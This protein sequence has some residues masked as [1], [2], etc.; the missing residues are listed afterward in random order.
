MRH[1]YYSDHWTL[2]ALG[3][4]MVFGSVRAASGQA[5]KA[6]SHGHTTRMDSDHHF[7]RD[8]ADHNEAM[9]HLAHS[10]MQMKHAHAGGTDAAGATDVVEDARKREIVSLLRSRFKDSRE[11]LPPPALKQQV[12][13]L[14]QLEGEAYEAG[15]KDFLRRHHKS[16]IDMIDQAKLRR[17]DV[18]SLVRKIR[19]QYVKEMA[20]MGSAA[21]H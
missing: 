7:L 2:V 1:R 10:A 12:D 20:S 16:A 3:L 19:A 5:G 8:L 6:V 14:M 21:A 13:A 17:S 9:V 15:M 11:P 18:R 4:L